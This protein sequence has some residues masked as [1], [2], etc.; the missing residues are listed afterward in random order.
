MAATPP[1]RPNNLELF[2]CQ[3]LS[4]ELQP[5]LDGWCE[6]V[7]RELLAVREASADAAEWREAVS[8]ELAQL[9]SEQQRAAESL[10]GTSSR[11]AEMPP[12]RLQ[13]K[14]E[15]Q[16]ETLVASLRQLQDELG[17]T[18]RTFERTEAGI[19]KERRQLIKAAQDEKT[20]ALAACELERLRIEE[21]AAE[22]E[23]RL[24]NAEA[25]ARAAA[26]RAASG[27]HEAGR[28]RVAVARQEGTEAARETA[29]RQ[30]HERAASLRVVEALAE[31][32]AVHCTLLAEAVF[33]AER[34]DDGR[35]WIELEAAH[36]AAV[37]LAAASARHE[38]RRERAHYK[39]LAATEAVVPQLASSAHALVGRLQTVTDHAEGISSA[40][41]G[42]RGRALRAE[43]DAEAAESKSNE[44][45]RAVARLE[46]QLNSQRAV[47]VHPVP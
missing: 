38:A 32:Q 16:Q 47:R 23:R 33:E 39:W 5:L 42:W 4:A 13:K 8:A 25:A 2:V 26:D 10:E 31:R 20:A 1:S 28:L 22:L 7:R 12:A 34:T 6:A 19:A 15:K 11:L 36:R 17:E 27:E 46:E 21:R 24:H 44:A 3:R 45:Q 35:Q 41:E 43:L 29:V 30:L 37:A 40:I 9:R 18:R 14:L